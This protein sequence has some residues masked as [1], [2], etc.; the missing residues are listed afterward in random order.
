MGKKKRLSDFDGQVFIS[1][2]GKKFYIIE[3]VN[4]KNVKYKFI[5]TG[6]EIWGELA[7]SKK[8][9]IHDPDQTKFDLMNK[10]HKNNNGAEYKVVTFNDYYNIIVEFLLSK[11]IVKT[12]GVAIASGKIPDTH[13]QSGRGRQRNLISGWGINDLKDDTRTSIFYQTWKAMIDR[14]Q[15]NEYYEDVSIC[16][17]WKYFSKFKE[18]MEIQDY[19]GRQLDKDILSDNKIYSPSTCIFV[20]PYTNTVILDSEG[21]R[22][23][24]PVGVHFDIDRVKFY[25]RVN[26]PSGYKFLGYT[27]TA[28]ES[29]DNYM[30]AKKAVLQNAYSKENKITKDALKAY[31]RRK[32]YV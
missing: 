23:E 20:L 4:S 26:T 9:N 13:L 5:E 24:L 17:E 11:N 14:V 29:Q 12:T 18:W 28:K 31:V 6:T 10:L 16:E 27:N 8:G 30:I 19:I 2:S 3:Y 32:E 7:R 25:A 15:K 1:N 21:S 22:S